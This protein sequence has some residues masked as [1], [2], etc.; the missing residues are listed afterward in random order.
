M[1]SL[2]YGNQATEI[3][4]IG[5]DA[6][7]L[8]QQLSALLNVPTVTVERVISDVALASTADEY[9]FAYKITF[10]QCQNW[11]GRH[12][13]VYS[14]SLSYAFGPIASLQIAFDVANDLR[15][16]VSSAVDVLT[17]ISFTLCPRSTCRR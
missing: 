15:R 2:A 16:F 6:S 10:L 17:R 12:A 5:A 8:Q 13:S 1:F 9:K 14:E 11:D 4:S 7:V 3:I